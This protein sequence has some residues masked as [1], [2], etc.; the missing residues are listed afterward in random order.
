MRAKLSELP[1]ET[2]GRDWPWRIESATS[3]LQ[4][5]TR[6][7]QQI[8]NAIEIVVAVVFDFDFAFFGGVVNRN[9]G[10]E[11]FLKTL[12]QGANVNVDFLGRGFFRVRIAGG[13]GE[14]GLGEFFGGA[15]GQF[16]A[17]DLIRGEFLGFGILDGENGFGVADGDLAL[18]EMD[19]DILVEVQQAHGIRHGGAGFADAGGDFFLFE[20]EFL[21]ESDVTGGFLDGIEVFALK[22]FNQCHFQHITIGCGALDDGNVGET[23]FGG[24]SPPAFTCDEFVF[25]INQTTDQ[26]LDDS[27]LA[28]RIHEIVQRSFDELMTRLERRGNNVFDGD[29]AHAWRIIRAT[30]GSLSW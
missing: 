3:L 20:G 7:F 14:Q 12:G 23:E 9:V 19:L 10:G 26:R 5:G 1:T 22:V 11:M 21:G 25:S 27:V 18:G 16:A 24:C 17:D 4:T 13:I 2:I 29:L 28:D 15:D 30:C 8:E 6:K